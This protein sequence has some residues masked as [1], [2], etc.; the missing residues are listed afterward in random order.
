[1]MNPLTLSLPGIAR[2]S[3]LLAL[4]ILLLAGCSRDEGAAG[5]A[6]IADVIYHS[7]D[8]ITVDDA[9]PLAEAV[10][11]ADGLIVA[12]GSA[13]EVMGLQGPETTVVD[14]AG[15]TMTPGSCSKTSR[16][17]LPKLAA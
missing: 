4:G 3:T 7:G 8:I 6:L 17:R 16:R 9:N 12:V 2:A 11:V 10:A 14:L 5:E 1:M 15:R 13:A